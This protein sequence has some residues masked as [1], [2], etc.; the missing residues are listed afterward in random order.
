MTITGSTKRLAL[1]AA[2]LL[3]AAGLAAQPAAAQEGVRLGN[4][5]RITQ[6]G[7]VNGAQTALALGMGATA[8]NGVASIMSGR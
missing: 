3:A 8:Q 4:N 1:A 2:A 5:N 7:T 6:Q